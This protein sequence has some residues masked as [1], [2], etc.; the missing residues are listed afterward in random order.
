MPAM[1]RYAKAFE[2]QLEK[3]TAMARHATLAAFARRPIVETDGI[4][5][6]RER[7]D[8]FYRDCQDL[9]AE[10]CMDVGEAPDA[11]SHK[12]VALTRTLDQAG[13]LQ[14]VVARSNGRAFGYL[15]SVISPSLESANRMV[16]V[17]TTFYASKDVPGLGLKLQRAALDNLKGLGVE[18]LFMRAGPRGSG[19]RMGVLYRRLGAAPDGEMYRLNLK[20]A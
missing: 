15:M 8:V 2:P 19:P 4:T 7:F 10:H 18:E 12:N 6:S 14:I 3:L 16:A 20:E 1:M 17:H 13:A 5:I 11:F 9:F